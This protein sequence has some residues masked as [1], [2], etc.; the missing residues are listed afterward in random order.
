MRTID[1]A[2]L[3]GNGGFGFGSGVDVGSG[4]RGGAGVGVVLDS[5]VGVRPDAGFDFDIARTFLL[6]DLDARSRRARVRVLHGRR[7]A[8]TEN[9]VTVEIE[10]G[11]RLG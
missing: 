2:D 7:A 8:A 6:F 4:L 11:G 10:I 1:G 3:L 5:R 9:D